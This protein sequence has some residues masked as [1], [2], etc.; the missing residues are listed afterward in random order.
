MYGP[1]TAAPLVFL[2]GAARARVIPLD[3][4]SI[5]PRVTR[6]GTGTELPICPEIA[7][8]TQQP[9]RTTSGRS[10]WGSI[11][12]KDQPELPPDGRSVGCYKEVALDLL[13]RICC[14][15]DVCWIIARIRHHYNLFHFV[16]DNVCGC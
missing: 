5:A 10:T 9:T 13:L 12:K 4:E 15:P 3:L 14:A 7:I 8:R 11:L 2:P 1:A 6:V 16:N